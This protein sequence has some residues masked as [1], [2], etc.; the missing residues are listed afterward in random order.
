MRWKEV[1]DVNET[2]F[3]TWMVAIAAATLIVAIIR[4]WIG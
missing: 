4:L 3:R 1:I 2:N